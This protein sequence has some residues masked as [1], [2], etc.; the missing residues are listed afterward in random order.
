MEDLLQEVEEFRAMLEEAVQ[1]AREKAQN[2][3]LNKEESP[4]ME[5]TKL[6]KHDITTKSNK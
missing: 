6:G 5:P 3:T 4:N 1:E 2:T